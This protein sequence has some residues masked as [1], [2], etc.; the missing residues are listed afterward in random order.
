MLLKALT[1]SSQLVVSSAQAILLPAVA[2]WAYE[3]DYLEDK[4]LMY[5]MQQLYTCIK[6][7]VYD[8]VCSVCLYVQCVY[9]IT[10]NLL[11]VFICV[12]SVCTY[13][14]MCA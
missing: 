3:I 14:R 9:C 1:D 2:A 8:T 11:S 6:V 10:D 7:C 5:F 12:H 13:V 4:L